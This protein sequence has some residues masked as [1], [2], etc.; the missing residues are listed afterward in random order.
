MV[1]IDKKS[2]ALGELL[3]RP[4]ADSLA[5]KVIGAYKPNVMHATNVANIKACKAA[6]VESCAKLL[7]FK[8]RDDDDKKLY[9][10]LDILSDRV[11]LKIE[12]LFE[13]MCDECHE[14]YQNTLDDDPILQCQNCMQGS[15]G[16]E[17]FKSKY[18]A[19][20]QFL[21]GEN[22]LSGLIWLCHGCLLKNDTSLTSP[23]QMQTA[24]DEGVADETPTAGNITDT[25]NDDNVRATGDQGNQSNNTSREVPR[26][27]PICELY[28]KRQCPH[29]PKGDWVIN[30]AVCQ[31]RHPPKCGRY[32]KFGK[33]GCPS[34]K[35]CKKWH[36]PLCYRSVR[37]R[38]CIDATCQYYHLKN[39]QREIHAHPSYPQNFPAALQNVN[40]PR[41]EVTMQY[42]AGSS[43]ASIASRSQN[44][45]GTNTG[46]PTGQMVNGHENCHAND[47]N[48]DNDG[49]HENHTRENAF[50]AQMVAQ[51]KE[52]L[53]TAMNEQMAELRSSIPNIVQDVVRNHTQAGQVQK[54]AMA[55]HYQQ[56]V[57]GAA[58]LNLHQPPPVFQV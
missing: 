58:N 40:A 13:I 33:Y 57:Q 20:K 12:S 23:G 24:T 54:Y 29:G 28:R 34:E 42:Q 47:I 37:D 56:T 26:P 30:G 39:T 6:A 10:N 18:E 19:L 3:N 35:K 53:A 16:C 41:P 48:N 4:E 15:H 21:G 11:I 36:P 1:I 17:S 14:E 9:K 25:E 50:L 45:G 2:L 51:I 7:G 38:V 5:K 22:S 49:T 27:K 32:M 8:V 43:Y 46:T 31:K 44:P 55:P 52:G